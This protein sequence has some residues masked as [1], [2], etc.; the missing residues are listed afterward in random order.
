MSTRQKRKHAPTRRK[1]TECLDELAELE[2]D[3]IFDYFKPRDSYNN[4]S[5]QTLEQLGNFPI[6]SITLSRAPIQSFLRRAINVVSF[7]NFE[8][9]AAKYGFDRLFHLS[10]L[11]DVDAN[12]SRRRVVVEKNAVIN[13]STRFKAERDAEYFPIQLRESLTLNAMMQRTQQLM[14]PRFFPYNAFS[15]NCQ[16]FI[17]DVLQANGLLTQQAHGWLFQDVE[18]LAAELPEVSK[19][20]TNAITTTGAVVDNLVGN[21]AQ[22]PSGLDIL[23]HESINRVKGKI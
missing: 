16:V 9:L 15:N 21:G 1:K 2:G 22:E 20:I 13:I 23:I 19:Q 7:G 10:M 5:R 3:G 4:T 6:V 8:R 14:G 12:G 11:V 18:Q 17:R